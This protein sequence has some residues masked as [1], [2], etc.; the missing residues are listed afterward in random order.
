[1]RGLIDRKIKA[2]VTLN[3]ARVN[4]LDKFQKLIA[5]Y[6]AGS[7]NIEAL[8]EE[9]VRFMQSLNAEDRRAMSEGLSEEELALFDLLTKPDPTLSKKEEAKVKKV[10]RGLLGTLKREKLVLAWRRRQQ[11][12]QAVRLC[13]EEVLDTLPRAYTP[14]VYQRKCDLTYQHVYDKYF[15]EGRSVY[16]AAGQA[17]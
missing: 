16:A 1:M 7:K 6:N 13:I 15:G 10:A 9:L 3:R 2:M 11:S 17:A 5:E 14:E 12:R 4:Y 8:F